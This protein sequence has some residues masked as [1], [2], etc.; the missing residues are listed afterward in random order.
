MH[1]SV[2]TRK[3]TRMQAHMQQVHTHACT[4]AHKVVVTGGSEPSF[5]QQSRSIP[6][7][8]SPKA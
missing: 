7:Q 8:D 4:Q 6:V 3:Y 5:R 2:H 1:A